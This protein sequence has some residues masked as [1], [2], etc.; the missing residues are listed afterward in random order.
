LAV[1]PLSIPFIRAGNLI[2]HTHL[3][4]AQNQMASSG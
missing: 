1:K 3:P 4:H 2:S